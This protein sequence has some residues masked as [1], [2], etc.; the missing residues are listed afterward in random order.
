M[1]DIKGINHNINIDEFISFYIKMINRNLNLLGVH[2][3]NTASLSVILA[4]EFGFNHFD[5]KTLNYGALLHDI[6]KMFVP[7]EI[8]NASRMLTPVEFEIIK[9]HTVAGWEALDN[10]KSLPPEI[11]SFAISHHH[12]NGFGYPKYLMYS[13]DIDPVLID[14]LT[15]ADSFSAIMEPRVY[16][17]KTTFIKSYEIITDKENPKNNGLNFDIL[18]RLKFLIDNNKIKLENFY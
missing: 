7:A 10:F 5:I 13:I 9:T 6:G 3:Q 12:R 16:K 2:S 17:E 1:I 8:L 18:D 11:K 15:V 14:I 4:S